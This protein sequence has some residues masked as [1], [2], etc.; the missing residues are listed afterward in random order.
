MLGFV[1]RRP[2]HLELEIIVAILVL[3]GRNPNGL[4]WQTDCS[5]YFDDIAN[6][7][8]PTAIDFH[9]GVVKAVLGA[10]GIISIP[11]HIG[12]A[13]YLGYQIINS[14]QNWLGAPI[15]V[16]DAQFFIDLASS[17]TGSIEPAS[18][19]DLRFWIIFLQ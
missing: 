16:I 15:I 12:L 8:D 5:L 14:I 17:S 7:Q 1:F 11:E 13:P 9:Q 18:L 6:F 4:I 3:D 10:L 2:H 19:L